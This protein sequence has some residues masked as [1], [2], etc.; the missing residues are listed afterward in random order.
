[1]LTLGL[2]TDYATDKQPREVQVKENR[3]YMLI[4]D[5]Q[6]DE[7]A[8]LSRMS[9][10]SKEIARRVLVDG[11]PLLTVGRRY[12]ISEARVSFIAKKIYNASKN[13]DPKRH[14]GDQILAVMK[15]SGV[16]EEILNKIRWFLRDLGLT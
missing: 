6:F 5:R 8:A 16:D 4:S 7:F 1:M 10:R 2:S 3:H 13:A 15:N 9:P 12:G 14:L 11:D